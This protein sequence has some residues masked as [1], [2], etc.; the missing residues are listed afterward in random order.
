MTA[1]PVTPTP[2]GANVTNASTPAARLTS[3]RLH[4]P[5]SG[6]VP[7]SSPGQSLCGRLNESMSWDPTDVVMKES[8]YLLHARRCTAAGG[9][10]RG[11]DPR[12]PTAGNSRI[13]AADTNPDGSPGYFNSPPVTTLPDTDTTATPLKNDACDTQPLYADDS[14]A[15]TPAAATPAA[16]SSGDSAVRSPA[17]M[18]NTMAGGSIAGGTPPNRNSSGFDAPIQGAGAGTED[19]MSDAGAVDGMTFDMDFGAEDFP[20]AITADRAAIVQDPAAMG[21]D[22]PV[23]TN[24]D[25]SPVRPAKKRMIRAHPLV[26]AAGHAG[27]P[28]E[29]AAAA[30]AVRSP[31]RSLRAR[32]APVDYSEMVFGCT[33]CGQSESS[34][35]CSRC[36]APICDTDSC[37][38]DGFCRKCNK[39]LRC[40]ICRHE[41]NGEPL[42]R[43]GACLSRAHTAC[44]SESADVHLMGSHF[45]CEAS[46]LA[47]NDAEKFKVVMVS[48]KWDSESPRFEWPGHLMEPKPGQAEGKHR[49]LF[50][51]DGLE[52]TYSKKDCKLLGDRTEWPQQVPARRQAEYSQAMEEMVRFQALRRDLRRNPATSTH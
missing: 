49:I 39:T 24:A 34:N 10:A 18:A 48:S 14:A 35:R 6:P 8:P 50:F 22:L 7:E 45:F 28:S 19:A 33:G 15:G 2:T 11:P 41:A 42:Q 13:G 47:A 1:T 16:S 27:V 26:V 20:D 52:D 5:P 36:R 25:A 30:P 38:I 23:A 9:P 43:C 3:A 31:R 12:G 51:G 17:D 29:T 37:R 32:T 40:F 46:V 4:S 21:A 44:V